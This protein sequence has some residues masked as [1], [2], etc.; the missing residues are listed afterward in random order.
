MSRYSV[1]SSPYIK[2]GTTALVNGVAINPTV[3]A[4]SFAFMQQ[5]IDPQPADFKVGSWE[6]VAGPPTVYAARIQIGPVSA[7]VL[8]KG[9]WM[10][11]IKVVDA[12]GPETIITP[13]GQV[14]LF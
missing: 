5:G 4:V 2:Y 8:A 1:L 11:W 13:V 3:D 9:T 7:N 12:T 6:T 10:V 14:E